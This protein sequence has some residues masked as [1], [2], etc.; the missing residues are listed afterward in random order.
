L[1]QLIYHLN[2]YNNYTIIYTIKKREHII[3]LLEEVEDALHTCCG[4]TMEQD[5]VLELLDK[6]K[7]LIN[8]EQK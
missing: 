8:G 5:K 6:I 1:K 4:I 2:H 7:N 3:L